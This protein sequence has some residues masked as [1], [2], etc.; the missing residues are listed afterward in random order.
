M[1]WDGEEKGEEEEEEK[2]EGPM[3]GPGDEG[4]VSFKSP[5]LLFF[6]WFSMAL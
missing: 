5:S 2:G 6:V 4:G 1:P 3:G